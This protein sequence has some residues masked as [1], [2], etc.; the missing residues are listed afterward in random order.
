M[1]AIVTTLAWLAAGPAD[2]STLSLKDDG[3]PLELIFPNDRHVYVVSLTGTWNKPAGVGAEH[4]VNFYF[5]NGWHYAHAVNRGA[6]DAAFING[7][8]RAMLFPYEM[9][10]GGVY[11]LGKVQVAVSHGWPAK[12]LQ[13]PY[14][15]SQPITLDLPF[16]RPV[17][18]GAQPLQLLPPPETLPSKP[19][20]VE[21]PPPAKG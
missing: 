14:L 10:R 13:S 16:Y 4:Y 20:P 17:K 6:D 7:D 8:V 2:P 21:T 15:I 3:K 18:R 1:T 12:D 5:P 9:K 19:M 11:P